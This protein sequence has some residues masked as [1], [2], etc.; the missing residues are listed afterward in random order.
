MSQDVYCETCEKH[1]RMRSW[2]TCPED[3]Y[4]AETVDESSKEEYLLMA[5]SEKCARLEWHHGAT[6]RDVPD[7]DPDQRVMDLIT[8]DRAAHQ[9]VGVKEGDLFHLDSMWYRIGPRGEA[10]IPVGNQMPSREGEED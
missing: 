10:P 2:M 3:W 1:G 7:E 8:K 9:M 6:K 5:C 4:W